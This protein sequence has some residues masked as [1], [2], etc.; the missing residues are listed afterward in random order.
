MFDL[1]CTAGEELG[2]T[3]DLT[4]YN[5][6]GGINGLFGSGLSSPSGSYWAVS[7]R[8]YQSK[9][10]TQQERIRP[11]MYLVISEKERKYG[12]TCYQWN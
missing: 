11:R 3:L 12:E 8:N 6:Q 4:D 5:G 10:P 7:L 1:V 2:H 9:S